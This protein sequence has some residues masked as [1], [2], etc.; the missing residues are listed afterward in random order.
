MNFIDHHYDYERVLRS[1][2]QFAGPLR[3]NSPAPTITA[4]KFTISYVELTTPDEVSPDWW[5]VVT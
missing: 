3:C 1:A 2:S 4:S 5:S